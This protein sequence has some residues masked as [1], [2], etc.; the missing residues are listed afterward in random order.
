MHLEPDTCLSPEILERFLAEELGEADEQT[1][2][3]HL[4]SCQ[5]CQQK[6][7]EAAASDGQWDE[8]RDLELTVDFVPSESALKF[9]QIVEFL[10]PSEDPKFVGRLGSY[11]VVG[12]V[13][14]GSTG[15]VLKAFEPRLNRFVAIK[16][17]TPRLA[18]NGA[19]RKRFER[20]G[21]A[22]A[23]VI[24]EHV[25]PIYAVSEH[26]NLPFI[27]MQYVPGLSLAQ[28]IA[29]EGPMSTCEVARV[30]FQVA[31]GLAAAHKQGIIHRDVKPANVLLE[32]T[33]D[34]AMVTD[35]GLARV[36]D[37]ATMT[38][39][40]TIS[41]T[42][43]FMSPEQA[44]GEPSDHRTDLFSLGSLMYAACTGRPPFRAET[45]FGIIHRVCEAEPRPVREINPEIH[46]WLAEL[47]H[48]L[49]AKNPEDRFANASQVANVLEQELAHLQN[50]TVVPV[51]N[52]DWIPAKTK[53]AMSL[54]D[55]SF[56]SQGV[57]LI[58]LIIGLAMLM[59]Y[60]SW[61][62]LFSN[63]LPEVNRVP[64]PTGVRTFEDDRQFDRVTIQRF[65]SSKYDAFHTIDPKRIFM[66]Q[67]M[68]PPEP[69]IRCK[70]TTPITR[71]AY[72][73]IFAG[74]EAMKIR[75]N[76]MGTKWSD[77]NETY[78]VLPKDRKHLSQQISELSDWFRRLREDPA[79]QRRDF[80]TLEDLD[81]I[82]PS[83]TSL[84]LVDSQPKNGWAIGDD[85]LEKISSRF[86]DLIHL[87]IP[88]GRDVSDEGFRSISRLRNLRSLRLRFAEHKCTIEAA[89]SLQ[90]LPN[91]QILDLSY[92]R[93]SKGELF[94]DAAMVWFGKFPALEHLVL[95]RHSKGSIS[96]RG[97][98]RLMA[99]ETLK[100]VFL[101]EQQL[102][103]S[104]EEVAGLP[105]LFKV[106]SD[107]PGNNY[108]QQ[109][110]S[111]EISALPKSDAG[112]AKKKRRNDLLPLAQKMSLLAKSIE[113][114]EKELEAVLR[115]NWVVKR[116][117]RT[118]LLPDGTD[119][120]SNR[121]VF[122][123]GHYSANRFK[124]KGRWVFQLS[125]PER[126]PGRSAQDFVIVNMDATKGQDAIQPRVQLEYFK[127]SP[128]AREMAQLI[129]SQVKQVL[130][131]V[132]EHKP[133]VFEEP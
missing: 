133:I 76:A 115:N 114:C 102:N 98:K 92:S 49:M 1:I 8:I 107:L 74:P 43:Q 42:P 24:H 99:S 52:R 27:V 104:N 122:M 106:V 125:W 121:D 71:P 61:S 60:N 126:R 38:R 103:L 28:R 15:I 86:P 36:T 83:T 116:D 22:I 45:V 54:G 20:E 84:R 44:R 23:A 29:S 80:K 67:S 131:V 55:F 129:E 5:E 96:Q 32:E 128:V 10:S 6:L 53:S 81:R 95:L 41:G 31:S 40:G 2:Q 87:E 47:I 123:S 64:S 68:F 39:S 59:V 34:R 78:E 13:G 48:K 90:K 21:R 16:I 75:L 124:F 120:D 118:A 97:I 65:R 4:D 73:L 58:G 50:P 105:K 37:D 112:N 113:S 130:T 57:A 69:K 88:E 66:L 14:Q 18:D 19:A 33:V 100:Q 70:K 85:W 25:V 110:F 62:I 82:H 111:N 72:D 30:G 132:V 101:S 7:E 79:F 119:P 9:T 51:P 109:C 3:A 26:R 56:S 108:F 127:A 117:I 89:E 12:V 93:G 77:G 46:A 94:S 91:L 11:E 17:L 35:F 63:S